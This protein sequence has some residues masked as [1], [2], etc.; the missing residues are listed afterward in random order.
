MPLYVKKKRQV[1]VELEATRGTGETIV[2]AD[3][4][5]TIREAEFTI[6]PVRVERPTLRQ[7]LTRF[8][9]IYAGQAEVEFNIL[10][11]MGGHP[12]NPTGTYTVPNFGDLL[13]ACGFEQISGTASGV[14]VRAWSFASMTSGP[15]RHGEPITITRATVNGTGTM[16][17]DTFTDDDVIFMDKTSTGSGSVTNITGTT[18]G[19]TTSGGAPTEETNNII[20]WQLTSDINAATG[21]VTIEVY[22]DGKRV[23]AEG[24]AGNVE[25]LCNHGDTLLARYTMRGAFVSYTETT[26]SS[27]NEDHHRAPTF[28]GRDVR[29]RNAAGSELYGKDGATVNGSINQMSFGPGNSVLLRENSFDPSGFSFAVITDRQGTGRINPDEIDVATFDFIDKLV[30]GEVVRMRANIGTNA[31]ADGNT[32]DFRV[33]G[34]VFDALGDGDRDGVHA[35]DGSFRLTGGDYDATATGELP[36]D[37]N[38]ITICHR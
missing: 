10:V 37:D 33:P 15:L 25:F 14:G 36:G 1:A 12:D 22:A 5:P 13:Q 3:N 30:N 4:I 23:R 29:L 7:N 9:D 34:I 20:A 35:W 31:G 38:E 21:G 32:F 6:T 17:G 2:G 11:E 18:S 16:I 27:P 8:P 19:A 26:L 28:L 24:C